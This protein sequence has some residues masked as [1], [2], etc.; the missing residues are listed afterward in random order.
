[1]SVIRAAA[2]EENQVP[3]QQLPNN[4]YQQT[5]G[6]LEPAKPAPASLSSDAIFP[7]STDDLCSTL[8]SFGG[9][10]FEAED[11]MSQLV[12][13]DELSD[14]RIHEGAMATGGVATT[15]EGTTAAGSASMEGAMTTGGVATLEKASSTG[16]GM[17]AQDGIKMAAGSTAGGDGNVG[18]E[19]G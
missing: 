17:E 2:G 7:P 8:E 16:R 15:F 1:M 6:P 13:E 18:M 4:S 11:L 19:T 5:S 9:A 3:D 10:E 12:L 14:V